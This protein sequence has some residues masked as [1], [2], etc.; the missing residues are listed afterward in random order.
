MEKAP[1]ILLID[2]HPKD[3][4]LV[5]NELRRQ[6][7]NLL[8][9]QIVDSTGFQKALITGEYNLVIT[10]YQVHWTD[11]FSI[12]RSIQ[13]R[14][15][16]CP[17]ILITSSGSEETA[18]EALKTGFF[19]YIP[20]SSAN[21]LSRLCNAVK[22]ALEAPLP[23]LKEGQSD[24][25]YYS[26][27]ERVPV[28]LYRTSL[29][30]RLL[31]AN[32]ALIKML[33]YPNRESLL[34]ED[35]NRI[36][37]N[38]SDRIRALNTLREKGI[39]EKF[40]FQARRYDGRLIW[41][42]DNSRVVHDSQGQIFFEGS[43]EDITQR[44]EA[45][46]ALREGEDRFRSFVE[47]I[48]DIIWEID[49][50]G[51]VTYV[52]PKIYD[53]LGYL[54]EEVIGRTTRDL[55]IEDE[56][57]NLF[58]VFEQQPPGQSTVYLV[59]GRY[60]HKADQHRVYLE[61]S[62]SPILDEQGNI[63]GFRGVFRDVTER[64]K[65]EVKRK[66]TEE[67]LRR[68]EAILKAISHA[69]GLFLKTSDWKNCI[70]EVLHNF[71][72]ATEVSRVYLF[73]NQFN[74][75]QPVTTS[76]RYEW[77][78]SR[79]SAEIDNPALQNVPLDS[80]G[81]TRLMDFLMAGQVAVALAKDYTPTE[82][83]IL[84]P[85]GVLSMLEVP[86]FVNGQ[87]W[88]FI[89]F[90]DC[91]NAREWS[92][93]EIETLKA[94]ADLLSAA[95]QRKIVE[96]ALAS[97]EIKFKDL[98]EQT[99]VGIYVINPEG[100]FSYVNPR[101]T[102]IL[103]YSQAELSGSSSFSGLIPPVI[104]AEIRSHFN[105]PL[106]Q[107]DPLRLHYVTRAERKDGSRVNIEVQGTEITTN[108]V[109]AVIGTVL[110]ITER[111]LREQEM[112]TVI[113]VSAALRPLTNRAEILPKILEQIMAQLNARA[114]MIVMSNPVTGKLIFE[115]GS[116]EWAAVAGAVLGVDE[117]INGWVI[118][119]G[120]PYNNLDIRTDARLA[121]PDL[122]GEIRSVSCVPLIAQRQTIGALWVGCDIPFTESEQR[123]LTAIG[124]IAANAIYRT[125]LHEQTEL[126]LQRLTALRAIDIAITS[127]LD[128]RVTLSILLSQVTAQLKVHAAGVMLLNSYTQT[129]EYIAVRGFR[130]NTIQHIRQR[131][132]EGH[133]G[134]VA[135]SR[136]PVTVPDIRT[137]PQCYAKKRYENEGFI[138]YIA[139]PL[140][141]K[142]QVKGVLELFYRHLLEQDT[143]WNDF[144]QA[145]AA[146][147]A[148][149]IDNAEL[150]EKLQRSN[151]DL[152]LAYDETIAGWA[153]AMEMRDRAS[154]RH[155]QRLTDM[156]MRL[157]RAYGL[158]EA[159]L[160]H[161]RRG[162]LLHDIGIIAIPDSILYKP[163]ALTAEEWEVMRQHPAY[164][165]DLLSPVPYLRPAIDIPYCHHEK[166]DGTGYPRGLRGDQIPI[167]AR[168]FS[169][170]DVWDALQSDRP[171]RSAWLMNLI[172]EYI[173]S[174]SALQFD[175][176]VVQL[177]LSIL[178]SNQTNP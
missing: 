80:P 112:E 54:P 176:A 26:L 95:I 149:A 97:V 67:A 73:E 116:G 37:L 91:I 47:S 23:A 9:V 82:R 151:V 177:F 138:G 68:R 130:D 89:G 167:A 150:F 126:S 92:E 171:Y 165:C 123:L 127:S 155:L 79:A 100:Q 78:D 24:N 70:S 94:A 129:L 178:A 109:P 3:R 45:E 7:N 159:D 133:A 40:E 144:L 62:A 60:I 86:I 13:S 20:K 27:V 170:V 51:R 135:V 32:P 83:Q 141:A 124:D 88:G 28:G 148:I 111:Y 16:G 18:V 14:T 115:M 56:A 59:E 164:A 102:E 48:D 65:A 157:G 38:P 106:P 39:L 160:V 145:I 103:G 166:W 8:L 143:E 152:T 139:T 172:V 134:R 42:E 117:G 161:I 140:I 93:V 4:S 77:T 142:G 114:A 118:R 44:K 84:E 41:V 10:E 158:S 120:Q 154:E 2:D 19:D 61:T 31:D 85:Q 29:E 169:V 174:Q 6:C 136:Q 108:G 57:Q 17:V 153:R 22:K 58:R 34:A 52:S 137:D 121:R 147:A 146:Q 66:L 156:T 36:Y 21:L 99:L 101:L 46:K 53:I 35:I 74:G 173:Q 55:D 96:E 87:W 72:E 168:I 49:G 125:T 105:S 81:F 162:V 175:P 131:L 12:F 132:G 5:A 122:F 1:R 63:T 104:L 90:D 64:R 50:T 76:Q 30:G 119:T 110:D 11:G 128:V 69:S 33:G 15:P 113:E 71:G 163:D 43:L 75:S 98:V 107:K 25:P